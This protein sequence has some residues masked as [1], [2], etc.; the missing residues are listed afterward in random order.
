[1]LTKEERVQRV[2][3]GTTIATT[4]TTTTNTTTITANYHHHHH[5]HPHHHRQ[6]PPPP[7]PP[8]LPPT[9][10]DTTITT[11]STTNH[12]CHCVVLVPGHVS[13]RVIRKE[14]LQECP[15]CHS[16][17]KSARSVRDEE[18]TSSTFSHMLARYDGRVSKSER[19]TIRVHGPRFTS[20]QW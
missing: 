15:L 12:H 16:L 5:H 17:Q 13:T 11:T 3:S 8:P 7:P 2:L 4:T 1:M 18:F 9:T 20:R 14:Y 6:P 10:T 19:T